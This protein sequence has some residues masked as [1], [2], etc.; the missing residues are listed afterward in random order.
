[1]I[2]TSSSRVTPHR[3][4]PPIW[5]RS[6]GAALPSVANAATVTI[7]RVREVQRRAL[8]DFTVDGLEHI[9]RELWRQVTQGPVDLVRGLPE[10]L[11]ELFRA[12]GTALW[13]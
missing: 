3:S 4:A 5:V 12:A 13:V 10:D 9:G 8:V 2:S 1:M 11:T 7:W 6:C